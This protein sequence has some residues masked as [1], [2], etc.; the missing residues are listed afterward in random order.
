MLERTTPE[1]THFILRALGSNANLLGSVIENSYTFPANSATINITAYLQPGVWDEVAYRQDV[2]TWEYRTPG[3]PNFSFLATTSHKAYLILD[4]PGAPWSRTE[5]SH[6]L[7]S[8]LLDHA[9]DWATG[10]RT[11]K[12]AANRICRG[13]FAL[14]DMSPPR[15]AYGGCSYF[16]SRTK[17]DCA[18]FLRALRGDPH[19]AR[20]VNC[21]DAA[22]IVS[23]FSNAFGANLCQQRC[24]AYGAFAI[25]PVRLVGER[26]ASRGTPSYHEVAWSTPGRFGDPVWDASL[27]LSGPPEVAA[28]MAFGDYRTRLSEIDIQ[29][30]VG[31]KKTR[32]LGAVTPCEDTGIS[33]HQPAA[34]PG[35]PAIFFLR[36]APAN[37]L[38]G[39][40]S[41]RVRWHKPKSAV[42]PCFDGYY[43]P[44]TEKDDILL[45]VQ[46]AAFA[47]EGA[48]ASYLAQRESECSDE[49]KSIA[50]GNG[51]FS[52]S[53][54]MTAGVRWGNAV[55]I[56]QNAGIPALEVL[57]LLHLIAPRV[58]VPPARLD[59]NPG[60]RAISVESTKQT[61]ATGETETAI[62]MS[63]DGQFQ[64]SEES[65]FL[66]ASSQGEVT[67]VRLDGTGDGEEHAKLY[68]F[69][70]TDERA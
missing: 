43:R 70:P 33:R 39:W 2:L 27:E 28:E 69:P 58:P 8:D 66:F 65:L 64:L 9:M 40:T 15:L 47:E 48:A 36:L 21:T 4:E 54:G 5:S 13:L 30:K 35:V 18:D 32:L 12:D 38:P 51:A 67:A 63:F 14:G 50:Q 17:F 31:T 6:F 42:L 7:V 1:I 3:A 49:V 53:D 23:T 20:R 37:L 68:R 25:K 19:H 29:P 46:F 56:F 45:R 44:S 24:G 34:T 26:T 55:Y 52:T 11:A 16:A 22:A 60:T 10:A 59:S 61:F 57:P 62:W 41:V